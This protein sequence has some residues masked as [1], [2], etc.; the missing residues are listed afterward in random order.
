LWT[1]A[2]VL[3][4]PLSKLT[5]EMELWIADHERPLSRRPEQKR[6]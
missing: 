6:T 3:E 5:G 2:D 1:I 4:T